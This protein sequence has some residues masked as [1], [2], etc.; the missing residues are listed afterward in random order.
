MAA[1]AGATYISPFVGRVDDISWEGIG[2]INQIAEMYAV[3]QFDTEILA[4]SIRNAK[5]IVDAAIAGADIVTC[6]LNSILGLLKLSLIH[7]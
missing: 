4:A 5:H 7:I 6:P 2:L 3:Q 1:K